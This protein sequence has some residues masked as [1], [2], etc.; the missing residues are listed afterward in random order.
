L[1]RD[2]TISY[3]D[4]FDGL[5]KELIKTSYSF[6]SDTDKKNILNNLSPC[7]VYYP[8]NKQLFKILEEKEFI[9]VRTSRNNYKITEEEQIG[10]SKK[11][12]GVVGLSVGRSVSTTI[13]MER[14]CGALRL[15]DFDELELSNLNRIKAPLKDI[16]QLKTVSTARE[17]K[18]FDPYFDVQ[19]FSDGITNENLND[20][21]LENGK[22][23][24]VID[25]CDSLEMKIL[26]RKKAKEIGVPVVMDTSDRGMVDI[27]RY[28]LDSNLEY[29]HGRIAGFDPSYTWKI[30]SEQRQTLLAQILDLNNLSEKA[31][32]SLSEIGK[33]ITTWPK[34]ASSIV[35]G[36]G[37]TAELCRRIL[38]GEKVPS[39]RF[40]IDLEELIPNGRE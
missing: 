18:E 14:S 31:K 28:D 17:I 26:L 32:Y 27:E 20:F 37:V 25:E 33:S 24:L 1:K 36:G 3:I 4:L 30:T 40:Y 15:A 2:V 12:I 13:A 38:L 35:L 9:K 19:L 21:F 8:W 11:K 6:C 22:L 16:G 7:W 10:L 34:L 5:K 29:F 39:G 23:D